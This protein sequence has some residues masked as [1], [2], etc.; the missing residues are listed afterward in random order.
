MT[1]ISNVAGPGVNS[2]NVP[3]TG[4]NSVA[5][6]SDT[7]LTQIAINLSIAGNIVA[8]L[9]GRY[10]SS[11][12][13][14]A[15]GLLNSLVQAGTAPASAQTTSNIDPQTAQDTTNQGIVGTLL[16]SPVT[17]G[18]YN[19]S[20]SLQGFSTDT[21]ANWASLL[22]ANPSLAAIVVSDSVNQGIVGMLSTLA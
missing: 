9:G 7:G 16:T 17:S 1:T 11:Q 19:S 3:V 12:T 13:Y 18:V 2:Y 10:S 4:A 6:T 14:N 8:T 5:Q 20:G 15:A 22:K 21:S